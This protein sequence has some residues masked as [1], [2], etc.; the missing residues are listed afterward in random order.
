MQEPLRERSQPRRKCGRFGLWSDIESG[1]RRV[2]FND[3]GPYPSRYNERAI[4][5]SMYLD[6]FVLKCESGQN[7][8]SQYKKRSESPSCWTTTSFVEP[9]LKLRGLRGP[10]RARRERPRDICQPA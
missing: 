10:Q 6:T 1:Q 5:G 9:N 2:F 7:S 8:H 3:K 4:Q